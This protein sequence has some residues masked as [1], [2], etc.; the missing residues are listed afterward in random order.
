MN[1]TYDPT[2]FITDR[3]QSDVEQIKS[4]KRKIA[5][6][7][8]GAL[9]NDEKSVFMHTN[10]KGY[11]Y[12]AR[13]CINLSDLNRIAWGCAMR[14]ME[15]KELG[16]ELLAL[17]NSVGIERTVNMIPSVS[18]ELMYCEQYYHDNDDTFPEV[19][20]MGDIP[21]RDEGTITLRQLSHDLKILMKW[22]SWAYS[23]NHENTDVFTVFDGITLEG[24]NDIEK[25]LQT[26][27]TDTEKSRLFLKFRENVE[28]QFGL[29]GEM[30]AN[31]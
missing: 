11:L 16:D 30:Y 31:E 20:V 14:S 3:T 27:L 7:G 4:L 26:P 21:Y 12:G 17:C 13:G 22:Y 19:W 6:E 9:S 24:L 15:Y 8:W 2:D 5:N 23:I 18:G 25:F 29:S 10:S 1:L 28:R